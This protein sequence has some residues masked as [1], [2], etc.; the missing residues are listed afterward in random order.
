MC[1]RGTAFTRS[2]FGLAFATCLFATSVP[3]RA[4]LFEALILLNRVSECGDKDNKLGARND[5]EVNAWRKK[6][7]N[8]DENAL[9]KSNPQ[10]YC[11]WLKETVLP[12]RERLLAR[13]EARMTD[14]CGPNGQV[15]GWRD[16]YLR[17][18]IHLKRRMSGPCLGLRDE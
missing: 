8:V 3:A 11:K 2:F 6:I 10:K 5:K 9:Q 12:I 17:D 14:K 7:K 4:Q 13:L 16:S 18:L 15:T 1:L